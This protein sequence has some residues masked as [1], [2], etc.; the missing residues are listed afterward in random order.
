MEFHFDGLDDPIVLPDEYLKVRQYQRLQKAL[1]VHADLE[2][3][4]KFDHL[5]LCLTDT[6]D[7]PDLIEKTDDLDMTPHNRETWE[8]I[9]EHIFKLVSA[10]KKIGDDETDEGLSDPLVET[11]TETPPAS[12]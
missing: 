7:L 3:V 4:D 10:A 6:F 11:P 2:K 5:R 9:E 12:D 1:V 8:N